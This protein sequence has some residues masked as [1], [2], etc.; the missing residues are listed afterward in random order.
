M[1]STTVLTL[2]LTWVCFASFAQDAPNVIPPSPDAASLGK[3]ADIPIST[4]TGIPNISVPLYQIQCRDVTVPITLNYHSGGIKVEEEA[5]WVGLGWSLSAGGVI[6]RSIRG[7][8][9]FI[10]SQGYT[11]YLDADAVPG[12]DPSD[13][14]LSDVC[15]RIFD[16][17]PDL[18]HF[19]FLGNSGKFFLKQRANTTDPVEVRLLSDDKVKFDYDE[20]NSIW[21]LWTKDGY[22]F[23]FGTKETSWTWSGAAHGEDAAIAAIAEPGFSFNPTLAP[24]TTSWYLDRIVSPTGEEVTFT[25][26][27]TDISGNPYTSKS[28]ANISESYKRCTGFG[29]LDTT[30]GCPELANEYTLKPMRAGYNTVFDFDC[31]FDNISGWTDGPGGNPPQICINENIY[32]RASIQVVTHQ[33]L[34]GITFTNGS[35]DFETSD[36]EDFLAMDLNINETNAAPQRLDAI[37]VNNSTETLKRFDFTYI[38]DT[39]V[40]GDETDKRLRLEQVQESNG[41]D[42]KNPYQF[43]YD[44]QLLPRKNSKS[45]DH[46]GYYNGANNDFASAAN[47]ATLI[48]AIT[49]FDQDGNIT[50]IEG[51]DREVDEVKAQAGILKR[52]TYPTGGYSEFIYESNTFNI[53]QVSSNLPQKLFNIHNLENTPKVFELTEEATVDINLEL[54]CKTLVCYDPNAGTAC[55]L[56]PGNFIDPYITIKSVDGSGDVFVGRHEDYDCKDNPGG[57]WCTTNN[58]TLSGFCGV[59]RTETFTLGPGKY[60]MIPSPLADFELVVSISYSQSQQVVSTTDN[61]IVKGGGVRVKQILHHDGLNSDNDQIKK[62]DYHYFDASGVYRSHGKLMTFPKYGYG[63]LHVIDEPNQD[64]TVYLRLTGSSNSNT[65]LGAS[66]QGNHIG[67]DQVVEYHGINGENG[68]SVYNYMND[69]DEEPEPYFPNSPTITHTPSNGLLLSQ[70]N[71]DWNDFKVSETINEYANVAGTTTLSAIHMHTR[72]CPDATIADPVYLYKYYHEPSEW[73]YQTKSTQIVYDRSDP[74]NVR[75]YSAVTDMEYSNTD[76][77]QMTKSTL[78]DSEGHQI[79]SEMKYPLDATTG[80]VVPQ[81]MLDQHIHDR[82]VWQEQFED[83]TLLQGTKNFYVDDNGIIVLDRVE[84]APDGVTYENRAQY[85]YDDM[86]NIVEFTPEDGNG[87]DNTATAYLW[88]YSQTLPIAQFVNATRTEVEAAITAAGLSLTTLQGNTLTEQ[89]IRDQIHLLRAQ[90]P[91][92]QISCYTYNPHQGVTSVTDPNNNTTYYEYDDLQRLQII[93]DLNLDILT[94]IEYQYGT[95][96]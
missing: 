95:Q 59:S 54:K 94:Q 11:G 38:Y 64:P 81:E 96:N 3:Y 78:T 16:A 66:A 87:R 42:S 44:N 86:G 56:N 7:V 74:A 53:D 36:R 52:I 80:I 6:T 90:L 30:V 13:A 14:Y 60:L 27:S 62:Y 8:G 47:Q 71:Y 28:I 2:F 32:H 41:V 50:T 48:P 43:S 70:E 25:Y 35:I 67:Y 9:D 4:Y 24:A 61:V 57:N 15:N 31:L 77:K 72:S 83:A 37:V 58:I 1:N 65:P 26:E 10:N 40:I 93:R 19:N 17:E 21:T 79:I 45:R 51:A 82:V 69:P 84:I 5:S 23:E 20:A 18:F 49:Y 39:G 55:V 68:R 89:Q 63:E 34:S 75:A 76:H 92:A 33:F 12:A 85:Q 91:D 22:Q 29:T 73:W 88:G 46:W